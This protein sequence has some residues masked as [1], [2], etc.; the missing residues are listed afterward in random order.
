MRTLGPLRSALP[1]A[2]IKHARMPSASA[3]NAQGRSPSYHTLLRVSSP[4]VEAEAQPQQPEAD[5][6]PI[7][8][9]E[10]DRYD[11]G[12]S[13]KRWRNLDATKSL[14]KIQGYL[15]D[16]QG[17]WPYFAYH[18][19]K[20][21]A[22][23]TQGLA[24]LL[25]ATL[26]TSISRS[27]GS[28]GSG[29]VSASPFL[30]SAVQDLPER[31]F[32]L[33]KEVVGALADD[34]HYVSTGT[35]KA[36]WDM[37]V[38]HRQLSPSFVLQKSA[39]YLREAVAT[40]DRRGRS[41]GGENVRTTTWLQSPFFPEYY[42]NSFHFQSDGWLSKRSAEVYE[43]STETLFL[44]RQDAM[45]RT[46]LLPLSS[47]RSATGAG[48]ME[49]KGLNVC[50]VGCGTGRFSTFVRDNM[51]AAN[52]TLV[53][54]SPFYLSEARENHQYYTSLNG[55]SGGS[56]SYVQGNAEDLS[57]IPSDSMDV[58]IS[59]YMFHELPPE[60]RA[61]VAAEMM[62]VVRPGG[63]V[64][65]T[66]SSQLGDRP[67]LD[68]N[69][70]NFQAFNEPFYGSYIEDDLGKYFAD[71]GGKYHEKHVSSVTKSIS[72]I[73]EGDIK[74]GDIKEGDMKEGEPSEA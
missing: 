32:G 22:F 5:T 56:V 43:T 12:P 18:G 69:L 67:E 50:E 61:L 6:R 72:F 47:W 26:A 17:S 19:L 33:G 54:M 44:G 60:S 63:L 15:R 49:G 37:D 59:V 10:N 66:D 24:S 73:K 31:A 38:R 28:I 7:G 25:L 71:A 51:K 11:C 35:F 29:A 65:L 58:C 4:E 8:E 9:R 64:V 39:L 36:P 13:V 1:G 57:T 53:D 30:Q 70:G 23:A 52:F 41:A 46:A 62:R 27:A 68:A 42:G 14:D 34:Y 16:D 48:A 40:L 21:T 3:A 55:E 45:Q 2:R 20:S 74:E